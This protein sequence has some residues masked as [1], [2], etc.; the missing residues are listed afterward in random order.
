LP[1]KELGREDELVKYQVELQK[2]KGSPKFKREDFYVILKNGKKERIWKP[3]PKLKKEVLPKG[4][5]FTN[6]YG[7]LSYQISDF[8]RIKDTF[9]PILKNIEYAQDT[10]NI[11]GYIFIPN[12]ST[13]FTIKNFK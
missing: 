4:Y 1:Y 7:N 3:D 13:N 8:P 2:D 10:M 11:E 12:G 5:E 6:R 9:V